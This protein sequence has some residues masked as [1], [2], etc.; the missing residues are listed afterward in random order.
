[1]IKIPFCCD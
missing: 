1:M